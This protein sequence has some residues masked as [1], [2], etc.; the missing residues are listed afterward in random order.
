MP[1]VQRIR[2]PQGICWESHDEPGREPRRQG[3]AVLST[4]GTQPGSL[5]DSWWPLSPAVTLVRANPNP[6]PAPSRDGVS[7]THQV[8]CEP[9]S[10]AGDGGRWAVGSLG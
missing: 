8:G 9:T 4:Q 10:P 1:G 6:T 3:T 5:Q 2:L 7:G